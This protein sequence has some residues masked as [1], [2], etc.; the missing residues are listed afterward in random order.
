MAD[1]PKKI[2][3]KVVNVANFEDLSEEE[4]DKIL[5][6]II[7]GVDEEAGTTTDDEDPNP[8]EKE[9]PIRVQFQKGVTSREILTE[10]KSIQDG[11]AKEFP[12]RAHRLYPTVFDEQ[13][14][15]IK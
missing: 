15:R 14:N 5:D 10:I 12:E 3:K 8:P 1:K 7:D 13:G 9:K 11:W 6:R 4:Q 2:V